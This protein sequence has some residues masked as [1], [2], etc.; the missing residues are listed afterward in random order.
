MFHNVLAFHISSLIST[1]PY[2]EDI[3]T[4]ILQMRNLKSE[5]SP[6]IYSAFESICVSEKS[7]LL[8]LPYRIFLKQQQK[9]LPKTKFNKYWGPILTDWPQY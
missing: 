2:E 8:V 5:I 1:K 7:V 9:Y 6:V 4:P 3:F